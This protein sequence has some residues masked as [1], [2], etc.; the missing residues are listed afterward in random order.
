[1]NC[2]TGVCSRGIINMFLVG[3]VSG[4]VENCNIGVFSD[5]M[6][7]NKCQIYQSSTF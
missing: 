4:L 6:N 3:Q 5:T 1:M 7:V 2:V